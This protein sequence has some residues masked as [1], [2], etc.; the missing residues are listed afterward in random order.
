MPSPPL[1]PWA[2]L[3]VTGPFLRAEK[4]AEYIGYSSTRYYALAAEGRLPKPIKL[5]NRREGAAVVPR[6]WLDAFV[7][8]HLDEI[9]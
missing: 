7:A 9:V 1:Q 4:A 5:G 2:G 3:P 6:G 8:S